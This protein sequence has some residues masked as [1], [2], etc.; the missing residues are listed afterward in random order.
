MSTPTTGQVIQYN[1]SEW[2]DS[3]SIGTVSSWYIIDTKTA[4]TYAGIATINTWTI[5]ELNSVAVNS[6]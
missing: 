3:S 1:G 4:G 5:R 2:T 6:W